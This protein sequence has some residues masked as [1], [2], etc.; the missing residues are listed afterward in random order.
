[1]VTCIKKRTLTIFQKKRSPE[2]GEE[3]FNMAPVASRQY[4]SYRQTS[5]S[6]GEL[7]SEKWGA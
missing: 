7:I 3:A 6:Y 5:S 4:P 2:Q 1:L